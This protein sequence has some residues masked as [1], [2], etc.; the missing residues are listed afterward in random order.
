MAEK[1]VDQIILA[2]ESP[3]RKQLLE[4]I[5]LPFEAVPPLSDENKEKNN[6]YGPTPDLA[7]YLAKIKADSLVARYPK[8]IIIGAD[9]TLSFQ[10]QILSKPHNTEQAKTRL[11]QL[12]GETH[13]LI[14]ALAVYHQG[15]WYQNQ[16]TAKMSMRRLNSKEVEHYIRLDNPVGCAGGYKI[17][18]HGPLLFEK[19][20]CE[21]FYS[22]IGIPLI[23]LCN[24]LRKIGFSAL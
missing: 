23:S 17:E 20:E 1:P 14:T 7:G 12:Q 8:A 16:V 5:G 13:I 24:I 18:C 10:G 15:K 19:I 9:Q 2:S 22:I 3:F 6:F 21:D 11:L 4:Q